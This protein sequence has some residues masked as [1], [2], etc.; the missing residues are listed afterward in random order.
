[1]ADLTRGRIILCGDFNLVIKQMRG[2]IDCK[3]PELQLLRHI[4]MEILRSWPIHELLHMKREWNQ[5]A[6]LLASKALQ[7]E[8]G[9]IALSDQDRQDISLLNRL[10]E[11]LTPKSVDQVVKIDAVTR[12]AVRRRRS[13]EALQEEFVRQVRIERIK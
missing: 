8:Q 1:M 3:A 6:D 5:S 12:S 11:L 10:D 4:A 2:E 9:L 7:Q 13:P